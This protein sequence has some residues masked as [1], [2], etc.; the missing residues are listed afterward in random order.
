MEALARVYGRRW[1]AR[2]HSAWYVYRDGEQYVQ[3]WYDDEHSWAARLDYVNQEQYGGVGIWVVNGAAD[4]PAMWE[5][6]RTAFAPPK[7]RVED[8]P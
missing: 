2:Q 1:D 6:L 4:S 8:A 3:G 7:P 5:M